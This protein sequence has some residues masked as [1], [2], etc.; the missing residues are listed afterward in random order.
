MNKAFVREP[1]FDGRAYCPHCGSL[2]LPV[3][4]GPL[5]RYIRPDARNK[6][7]DTAWF[8]NFH[9]CDVAYFN[10]F[11]AVVL[12]DE[13]SAPVYPHDLDAPLCACFGLSYDDVS[14]WLSRSRPPPSASR[15]QPTAAAAWPPCRSCICGSAA[16]T[17]S[18]AR[19]TMAAMTNPAPRSAYI[20]VPFCLH[21]CGYCDFAVIAG[22]DDLF[23]PY[24]AAL[25]TEL[26]WLAMPRPV[27]TL[28]FGGGTPSHLPAAELA[29]LCE[30]ATRWHPPAVGCE[31]TVEANPETLTPDRVQ[32]MAERGV[33][34]VSLGVQSLQDVK[35]RALDRRHD[36]AAAIAAVERVHAAGL[37]ASVD[38]IFAAPGETLA[39]WQADLRDAIALAPGHISTYGLT[40]EQGTAFTVARQ[41]GALHEL[42]EELQRAMYAEAIEALAAAGY[43]H[44]EVSNFAR[45]GRHS[46][47]NEVYWAGAE[48]Y[49]AGPGAARYV[50]GARETNIKSTLGY[51]ARVEAGE[52]PVADCEELPPEQRARE[53]LVLG[54]RRLRG[55]DKRE[56][57]AATGFEVDALAG[58][59]I[60]KFAA[61]GLLK[62]DP[63]GVRLTREGLFVSDGLWPELL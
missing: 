3:E 53:R 15:S 12:R 61:I 11:E 44:Y 59:A 52:S 33:T 7:G 16:A 43:E 27:E 42:D 30:L 2:G 1:D 57:A 9:R 55:V 14:C 22:R 31:W 50:A 36:R 6:L 60:A 26:S 47:H 38:L 25:A 51:L 17:E 35:L 24:L 46:R 29:R 58:P 8:C 56:F 34:R 5:D 40:F 63:S 48:Y 39:D 10:L 13:L 18:H 20:H 4:H 32:V 45:P 54:L 49:A 23:E 21:R 19:R 62:D 41:R 37:Q 28:Y